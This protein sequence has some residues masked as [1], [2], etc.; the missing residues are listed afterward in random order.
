MLYGSHLSSVIINPLFQEDETEAMGP[1]LENKL[2]YD[3]LISD[4]YHNNEIGALYLK[5]TVS[6][7]QGL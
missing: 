1:A 7:C 5:T 6:V 3:C 4:H 2:Y